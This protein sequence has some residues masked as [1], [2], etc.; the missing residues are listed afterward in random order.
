VLLIEARRRTLPIRDLGHSLD[1]WLLA[2][3]EYNIR[4][5]ESRRDRLVVDVFYTS[6]TGSL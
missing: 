4:A 5:A 2:R 3:F 1:T 6:R